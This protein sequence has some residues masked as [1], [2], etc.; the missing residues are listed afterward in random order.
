MYISSK[1]VSLFSSC[2]WGKLTLTHVGSDIS[3]EPDSIFLTCLTIINAASGG[4]SE[5]RENT[6]WGEQ[7][8]GQRGATWSQELLR[9]S[10]GLQASWTR[11]QRETDVT[12]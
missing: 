7:V 12:P 3:I 8:P 11:I 4:G 5:Y 1:S 10:A 2:A 9:Q 6:E